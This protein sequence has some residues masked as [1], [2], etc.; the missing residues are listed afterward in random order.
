MCLSAAPLFAE[1]FDLFT[2]RVFDDEVT[3]TDYPENATGD[4]AIP[5]EIDGKPVTE[6]G[7]FAFEDCKRITSVTIP[8]SVTEIGEEAFSTYAGLT[9]TFFLVDAP[10]TFDLS[11]FD[12][13]APDFTIYYRSGSTGFT[14]PRTATRRSGS[15]S[16]R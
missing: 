13:T 11:A 9:S 15:I 2:Y 4:V 3:I 10:G 8:E 16:C 6:I 5:A 7:G 12:E 1:Q 14:S